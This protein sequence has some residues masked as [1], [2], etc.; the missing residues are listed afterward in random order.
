M[1]K[2]LSMIVLSLL[3]TTGCQFAGVRSWEVEIKA[4]GFSVAAGAKVDGFY[5]NKDTKLKEIKQ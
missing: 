3:F 1:K 5:F 2:V 4:P